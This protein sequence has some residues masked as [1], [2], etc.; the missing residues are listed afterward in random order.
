MCASPDPSAQLMQLRQPEALGMFDHHDRGI[1]HIDSDLHHRRRD[2][3]LDLPLLIRGHDLFF[4]I[5]LHSSMQQPDAKLGQLIRL[6]LLRSL[7]GRLQIG[8]LRFFDERIDH[9]S[10]TATT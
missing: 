9:I 10:L 3:D 1:R 4:L 2:Q 5:R 8:L 7:H 6:Q